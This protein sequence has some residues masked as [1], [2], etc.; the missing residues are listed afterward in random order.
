MLSMNLLASFFLLLWAGINY[1][2]AMFTDSRGDRSVACYEW[3]VLIGPD[4][5]NKWIEWDR[6]A[7]VIVAFGKQAQVTSLWPREYKILRHRKW[8]GGIYF[9]LT[10]A[11]Q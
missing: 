6:H 9:Y 2:G 3:T 11:V 7:L 5:D 4:I 8:H 10:G 1:E